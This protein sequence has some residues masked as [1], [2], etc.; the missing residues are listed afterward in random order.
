MPDHTLDWS[1][2]GANG[3]FTLGTGSEAIGFEV[4]S[5]AATD[6]KVA[7]VQTSGSP[8]QEAL[9]VSG[10]TSETTTVIG[11]DAEVSNL[12]F[13]VFDLDQRAGSWDDRITI[14]AYNELGELVTINYSDL[15]GLHTVDGE[16]LNT[17]GNAST[18][19]ET[20]GADDSVSV[21]IP[22]PIVRL[23][24]VFDAGE[25]HTSSG[26]FGISDITLDATPPDFIVEGT[27]GADVID[28][29]YVGDL[30]GDRVDHSDAEDGSNDDIIHAGAGND[31]VIG[32]AGND[33]VLGGEGEDT[34]RGD[35]G[36]DT[37][38]GGEGADWLYGDSGHDVLI[39]GAGNDT[40]EAGTG[41]DEFHGG[42]GDDRV[43]GDYGNDTLFGGEGDD[44]LRGSFGNDEIHGGV[45][46]DY[47]WGGF[48]DDTFHIENDFGND[49]ITAEN[50]DETLGDTLDLSAV[51]DDLRID[52]TS[53]TPG[54]GS[55]SDGDST[56]TF[57]EIE[58]I[59][60]SSGQDT[61]VLSDGSGTDVV[62]GFSAPTLNADG[63]YTGIDMLD[64]TTLTRDDGDTLVT[65]NDVVVSA[66]G[67]GHAILTF[68]GGEALTLVGVT[69]AELSTPEALV[70]IGIPLGPD[71]IVSGTGG[72]DT[73][74]TGY[75]GDPD[76]DFVDNEDAL[77]PGE[78]GND[79]IIE[80]GAGNDLI[81]AGAGNDDVDAGIDDDTVFGGIGDDL[82]DGA[83]GNDELLGEIGADTLIG[84]AGNDS[85]SGGDD[86]DVL[87]GQSGAD[88]LDGGAGAD[89][90]LGG[91][92]ADVIHGAAGDTVDGGSGGDD[93]DTLVLHGPVSIAYDPDNSENGTATWNDGSTLSFTDIENVDVI[94]CFTT[95]TKIRTRLGDVPAG[96]LSVGDTVL[97]RDNGYQTIRW[98]GTKHISK[99]KMQGNPA[100]RPILLLQSSL[101]EGKPCC[102]T[103]LSPQHRVL[104]ESQAAELWF[105]DDEVLVAAQHLTDLD[106]IEV[107]AVD[108]VTY[109]HFV[110]DRH[111]IVLGDGVWSES[112]QPGDM[113]L[114]ALDLEQRNELFEIFPELS[115]TVGSVFPTARM[116]LKAYEAAVLFER[117]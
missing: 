31:S 59:V 41:N 8:A 12:N 55:F 79:D 82:I 78:T 65:T 26:N 30:E 37:L 40:A 92:D 56:A 97:T 13:E 27:S 62:Q 48:G 57:G 46:D 113:S 28:I 39:G 6:G 32:G 15:D 115:T 50:Q 14:R 73:I 42:I 36:N 61:L 17:H 114:G 87:K 85:L 106:N 108:D 74:F 47:L 110:F 89:L 43:N 29:D 33:S 100:L 90:L 77:L 86:D 51:T 95:D 58:H 5:T 84:G 19:V 23:E 70:A 99:A 22:G 54:T 111:E 16:V 117:P 112:F 25:S 2:S 105:G 34:L 93:N 98:V 45:G 96:S 60:L 75:T 35:I 18:G 20:V 53:A 10:L 67:D 107:S 24:F 68:P 102:D 104:I 109:V 21:A 116:S 52:L 101:G 38:D 1:A 103:L 7:Q 94:P 11:F 63:T 49:T 71:G 72:D 88:T 83:A 80:A 91:D 9:W 4:T 81:F 3:N 66:S 64:V 69:P 76:G 44:F